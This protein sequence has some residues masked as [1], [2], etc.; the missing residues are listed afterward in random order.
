VHPAEPVPDALVRAG[1]IRLVDLAPAA[2]RRRLSQGLAFGQQQAD[3]AP[4]P[5][6]SA[7]MPAGSNPVRVASS[8]A[9]AGLAGIRDGGC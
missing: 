9:E 1:E 3:A 8:R 4:S 5:S 7:G 6:A 2:L